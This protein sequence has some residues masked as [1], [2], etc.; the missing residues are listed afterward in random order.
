MLFGGF[1]PHVDP[2]QLEAAG[3]NS[4]ADPCGQTSR[5]PS[6]RRGPLV[7]SSNILHCETTEMT[8]GDGVNL[9][10]INADN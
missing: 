3:G 10:A 1:D 9:V 5:G 7:A 8:P 6:R 2:N 4:F